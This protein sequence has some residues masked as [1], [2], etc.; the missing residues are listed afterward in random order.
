MAEPWL[1]VFTKNAENPNYQA[2][3]HGTERVAS[4]QGARVTRHIPRQAD[5]PVE[6][7][8]LLHTVVAQRPD[9]ILFAPADD[10]ALE[11]PVAEVNAAGIPLIGFVNRMA[12]R[13][14]S[15]V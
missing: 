15:F 2:F 11:A 12:G 5:D 7:A 9:V 1:A 13:F 10:K 3:L 14:V 6:Q 8:T 4:A